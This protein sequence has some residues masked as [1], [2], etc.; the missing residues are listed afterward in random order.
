[1]RANLKQ[2]TD[3][4][5]A[6]SGQPE[7]VCQQWAA[8]VNKAC[9]EFTATMDD[10]CR[11]SGINMSYIHR[12]RRG[13]VPRRDMVA[14]FGRTVAGNKGEVQALFMAGYVPNQTCAELFLKMLGG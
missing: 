10:L 6:N 8:Y 7:W 1:M 4:K 13:Y 3:M 2:P 9:H 14:A 11:E 12:M 5:Y